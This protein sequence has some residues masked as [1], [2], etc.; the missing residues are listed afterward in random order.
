MPLGGDEV[1]EILISR[2]L[3]VE[4]YSTIDFST[5]EAYLIPVLSESVYLQAPF[6]ARS[7][8][9]GTDKWIL[10]GECSYTLQLSLSLW[11]GIS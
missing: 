4:R 1:D 9:L 3:Q 5:A 7:K 6:A 8:V 2:L 11:C 10:V